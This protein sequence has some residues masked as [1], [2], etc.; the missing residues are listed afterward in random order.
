MT[1]LYEHLRRTADR[2]PD[3]PA[4]T[5]LSTGRSL[6]FAEL[7]DRS[8]RIAARLIEVG[9]VERYD[10]IGLCAPNSLEYLPIAF[11]ILRAGGCL[12]PI[13]ANATTPEARHIIDDI[14]V[15]HLLVTPGAA[16]IAAL[17]P[18]FETVALDSDTPADFTFHRRRSTPAAPSEFAALDP[19][20]VRFT[21]GSTGR[22]KGVVLSH[23][24]TT[25]R[26]E[27]A[28]AR[29]RLTED[30][31]VLWLLPLAYHFAVTITAYVR[32]G[33]HVLLCPESKPAELASRIAEHRP[34]IVYASPV[35]TERLGSVG[36]AEALASVRLFISTAAP[37]RRDVIERF[38][39]RCQKPVTQAYGI[40]E[41][42]L[43]CIQDRAMGDAATSVGTP[44]PGYDLVLFDRE[45]QPLARRPD[46]EGEVGIR[47]A[48]LFSAYYRPWTPRSAI[49]RD[50]YF[51]TGDI[52]F[53][54]ARG[55]LHLVGRSK[56]M[57]IVGGMKFFPEE[58]E[59]VLDDHPAI[60]QSRVSAVDHPKLGQYPRAELVLA[61]PTRELDRTELRRFLADR[62]SSYKIPVEFTIAEEI[63]RTRS[64]KIR[65][66]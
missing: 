23:A 49:E 47:A 28:D 3:H 58:V 24:A 8:E 27:A 2:L 39:E 53:F 12:T 56:S 6:T 36:S 62:L 7:R 22:S 52:G 4:A 26:V 51:L 61:D 13:P 30:D 10:R 45:G 60:R 1:H 11:A 38:E 32:S 55:A 9:G 54:D 20:F 18:D 64:G 5:D 63:P 33:A 42:G 17:A 59:S 34:T 35:Q 21:S 65:R 46:V 44:V 41:A 50:G 15:G 57:I 37:I 40:I 43:P 14:D 48:G 31:R 29:L 16:D 25:A 19:A 66:W